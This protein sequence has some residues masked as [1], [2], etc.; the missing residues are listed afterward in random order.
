[1]HS[2]G[3]NIHRFWTTEKLQY[4]HNRLCT[5][6]FICFYPKGIQILIMSQIKINIDKHILYINTFRVLTLKGANTW[7]MFISK[8][9]FWDLIRIWR[10]FGKKYRKQFC[11]IISVKLFYN[12]KSKQVATKKVKQN[13]NKPYV[14]VAS[15]VSS[16]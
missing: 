13:I 2:Q 7:N 1:M 14:N 5:I 12:S 6:S 9:I 15:S 10:S 8:F 16:G 4:K 3:R 11:F